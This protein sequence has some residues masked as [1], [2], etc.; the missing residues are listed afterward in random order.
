LLSRVLIANDFVA[1]GYGLLTVD[2]ATECI[3]LQ[4]APKLLNAPI[5][6]IGAGTG[7]GQCF[8][9]PATNERGMAEEDLDGEDVPALVYN[10][11]PS[12][13]ENNTSFPSLPLIPSHNDCHTLTDI[14]IIIKST[15]MKGGHAEFAPRSELE[16]ELLTYLKQKFDQ[17]HRVSVERVVSGIGLAN[18]F[19]F[20]C[21]TMPD[22]VNPEVKKAVDTAG[23][24]KGAIIAQHKED[25]LC[26]KTME[27]FMSSYG[28][29]TGVVALKWLPYGGLY[30]TGGMTPKNID[31]I[32]DPDGPFMTALF[33]K[34]RVKSMLYTVPIFAVIAED[35]G[36][37]GA[38]FAGTRQKSS[39]LLP[40]NTSSY[41]Y[42]LLLSL[43][44]FIQLTGNLRKKY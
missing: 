33:D 22:K 15:S 29:E 31:L 14:L 3:C 8:L 27:V 21:A 39:L 43:I 19:E 5:A 1:L 40:N 4:D 9:T 28:S 32:K 37:R 6:C 26:V 30:L 20:F 34:G 17:K 23:D 11:F 16:F 38:H 35:L 13:G 18:V 44:T 36:E 41:P 42:L 10:C 12:E 2:D 24:M 7:L 25:E